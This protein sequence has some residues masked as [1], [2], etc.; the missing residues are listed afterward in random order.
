MSVAREPAF[1]MG[2]VLLFFICM[3]GRCACEM[4]GDSKPMVDALEAY[5]K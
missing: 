1:I 3:S 5:D 4:V 2:C